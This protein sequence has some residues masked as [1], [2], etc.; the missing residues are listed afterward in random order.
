[1]TMTDR[2]ISTEAPDPWRQR[3]LCSYCD[4]ELFFPATNAVHASSMRRDSIPA[5][6]RRPLRICLDCPVRHQCLT[7]AIAEG[8][9]FGVRG[10]VFFTDNGKVGDPYG[11]YA[12]T[13]RPS[14]RAGQ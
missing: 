5:L 14:D 8:R 1:M 4:P 3:A 10:G 7:E 11:F 9:T 6:L 12:A 2:G 13:Q